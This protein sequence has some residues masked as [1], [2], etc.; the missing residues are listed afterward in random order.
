MTDHLYHPGGK[1]SIPLP[2]HV[3]GRA[4]FSECGRYRQE[5]WRTW[6]NGSTYAMFIGTNPSTASHLVDD[7]TCL[8]EW[9]RAERMGMGGYAKCN[10]L[11]IRMTD[12]KQLHRLDVPPFSD[13]NLPAILRLAR[14][15]EVIIACWG[16]LHISLKHHADC[17]ETALRDAGHALHCLGQNKDGS[18][19]HP[20]Y[21]R[22]DAPLVEYRP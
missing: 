16:K 10:V 9:M 14:K 1:V 20:L 2:L 4:T 19:K 21:L 22:A 6:S 12:A 7:P 18:P 3:T 15:A 8:R 5:L 17:V 11:D 13:A